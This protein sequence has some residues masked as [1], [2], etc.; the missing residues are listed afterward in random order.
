MVSLTRTQKMVA[1]ALAAGVSLY[2]FVGGR[3]SE[4]VAQDNFRA[5][6]AAHVRGVLARVNIRNH[7]VG[8]VV[9]GRPGWLVFYPRT[10]ERLNRGKHFHLWAQPGD[11]V[12]KPA[13]SDTLRLMKGNRVYRYL[14]QTRQ[15]GAP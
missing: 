7:G 4:R 3:Y 2:L 6:D 5:F 14:F 12:L 1:A 8:I 13:H 10:D 15:R 9:R 11:S